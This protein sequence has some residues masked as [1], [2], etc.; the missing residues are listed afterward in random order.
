VVVSTLSYWGNLK[1][2]N[3]GIPLVHLLLIL[4]AAGISIAVP[5]IFFFLG[6]SAVR[7]LRDIRDTLHAQQRSG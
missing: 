7:L 1:E 4:I 5:V 6:F 2:A 3:M